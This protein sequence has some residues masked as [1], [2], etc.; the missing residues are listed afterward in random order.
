M[1]M[2][3]FG[4]GHSQAGL[5]GK[6]GRVF[7]W[8]LVSFF[9]MAVVTAFAVASAYMHTD[10]DVLMLSPIFSDAIGWDIYR[11][12]EEGASVPVRSEERRVGKECAI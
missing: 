5:P 6:T 4:K 12:D 1:K 9:V 10:A 8:V 3:L 7:R 11:L 2:K